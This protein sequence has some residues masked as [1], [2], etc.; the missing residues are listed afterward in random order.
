MPTIHHNYKNDKF[1]KFKPISNHEILYNVIDKLLCCDKSNRDGIFCLDAI[2]NTISKCYLYI[3]DIKNTS[4]MTIL[5]T[6]YDIMTSIF[7]SGM[8]DMV[9]NINEILLGNGKP[10][11]EKLISSNNKKLD[12][13]FKCFPV[14]MHIQYIIIH[15][16]YG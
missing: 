10:T 3:N 9:A 13:V 4:E 5:G 8:Y 2:V 1:D 12:Q 16:K 11:L 14:M 15:G 7:S 6:I